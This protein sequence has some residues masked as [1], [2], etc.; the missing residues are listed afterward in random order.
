MCASS[1]GSGISWTNRLTYGVGQVAGAGTVLT[2][3]LI[4]AIGSVQRTTRAVASESV[5]TVPRLFRLG[6][7]QPSTRISLG[8][9][10]SENTKR[11]PHGELFLFENRVLTHDQV[12]TRIDNVVAGLIECGIRPGQHIGVMMDPRPSA[13]V[14]VAALSRLGAVAV[15]LSSASDLNLMLTES[16]VRVIVADPDHLDLAAFFQF[17][18]GV[19]AG[20]ATTDHHDIGI[21]V[22][23]QA[24]EGEIVLPG[25]GV[26]VQRVEL[27]HD[28]GGK[29][30]H[31]VRPR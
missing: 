1:G 8:K 7:I 13:L 26:V 18:R 9:L 4:D 25:D 5:R 3:E 28:G 21:D 23:G 14:A 11:N 16:D 27:V 19:D 24:G 12:N 6:Q 2:K 10:M 15:M 17:Q 31:G 30:V 29:G 20:K 22:I